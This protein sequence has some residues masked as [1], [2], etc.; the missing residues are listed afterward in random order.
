MHRRLKKVLRIGG[1]VTGVVVGLLA[2]AV[3]LVLFDKPL[4]RNISQKFITKKA[5]FDVKIGKLDYTLFPLHVTLSAVTA[6][7][8]TPNYT[9]DVTVDRVEARGDLHKLLNGTKPAFET[10]EIS[11]AELRFDQSKVSEVPIDFAGLVPQLGSIL[12]YSE[13]TSIV[14]RSMPIA[15]PGQK[16]QADDLALA[17]SRTSATDSFGLRLDA[18][19]FAAA[20]TAGGQAVEAPLHADGTLTLAGTMVV[21]LRLGLDSPRI[22][23][24]GRTESF[25]SLDLETDG[26]WWIAENK[27]S[28][29]KLAIDVPDLINAAAAFDAD[30]GK[31]GSF[32]ADGNARF[33]KLEALAPSVPILICR[34][35]CAECAFEAGPRSPGN[36]RSLP[37]PRGNRPRWRLRSNWTKSAWSTKKTA[38]LSSSE[39]PG[40][41]KLRYRP[42]PASGSS[43]AKRLLSRPHSSSIVPPWSTAG[44]ACR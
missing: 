1:I 11:I 31:N 24:G 16:F 40:P 14:C 19:R 2:A 39:F 42:P 23:A 13:R 36:T 10:V 28:L 8:K 22:T 5:G 25:K 37:A 18:R 34:L 44:P 9:M 27:V 29:R 33:E 4:V 30:F 6:V 41:S 35:P 15:V 17:F 20:M 7:Y 43:P 21:A 26:T 38:S 3:L 32:T 12:G